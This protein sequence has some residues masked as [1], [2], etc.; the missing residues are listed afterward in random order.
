MKRKILRWMLVPM[1]AATA[2]VCFNS[3]TEASEGSSTT[4]TNHCDAATN[5]TC[6]VTINGVNTSCP[7][8]TPKP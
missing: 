5:V 3:F 4:C 6:S 1:V 7:K 2:L 8:M